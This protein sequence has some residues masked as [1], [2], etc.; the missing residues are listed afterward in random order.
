MEEKHA[1]F[2]LLIGGNEI[3]HNFVLDM[4]DRIAVSEQQ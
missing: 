3:L 2:Q 4:P 1:S